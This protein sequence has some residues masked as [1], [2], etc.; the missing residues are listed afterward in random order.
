MKLVMHRHSCLIKIIS[1]VLLIFAVIFIINSCSKDVVTPP[2][3]FAG[4]LAPVSPPIELNVLTSVVGNGKI[5][6]SQ[7]NIKSGRSV[8]ITATP[9]VHYRLKEWKGDCGTF[10]N[11]SLSIS[12]KVTD[13]CFIVA[14]F[15]MIPYIVTA[16]TYEGGSVSESKVLRKYNQ[17]VSIAAKPQE[18]YVFGSWKIM[19]ESGCPTLKDASNPI[20]E[21]DVIGNCSLVAIFLKSPR[22]ITT[23]FIT[24][25]GEVIQTQEVEHGDQVDIT[26]K[27]EKHYK[28]KQWSGDCGNFSSDELNISFTAVRDCNIRIIFEKIPYTFSVTINEGGSVIKTREDVELETSDPVVNSGE[29]VTIKANP[30]RGFKFV[31]WNPSEELDCPQL[32]SLLDP[33]QTLTVE[34]NCS[35]EAVFEEL[36][37][38]IVADAETGGSV[39]PRGE[40]KVNHGETVSIQ[41]KPDPD[42]FFVEWDVKGTGCSP[43]PYDTNAQ[44]LAKG[45]CQLKAVFADIVD[46]ISSVEDN[47]DGNPT[48]PDDENGNPTD[49][50]DENG[51]PTDPDDE[52]GNPTD[53]DDE[54]GN[55]TDPDDENGNPTDPDDENGNPTDP[56]DENGNPTDPDDENGNPTDPDDENGNPTDPDDENGNPT[57]PDDENGN[58]TDPDDENGNPTDPD[59]EN[60]NPT[61]PDDENGNPTDP[62]D[63]NGN[64]TDP[65][66]ENGNPTDPD[67]E[68]GN[69]TDPDDE[70]GNPTDPDDENG[71]P[72]DPDDE[73]GDPTDPDND[74]G[75]PSNPDNDNGDPSNPDND[76][77]D[78]SNPDNDNGDP[79]NPDNDNGDPSNPDNDNGD[80]NDP[81]NDNGD[82]NDPDND[83]GDPNNPDN[84]NSDPNDP[85]N[86]NGDPN[87]PDNDNGDP[88][89]PGNDN[90]DPNNNPPSEST[91]ITYSITTSAGTGGNITGNKT[92]N[93]GDSV[94]ITAT[95]S[96]GYQVQSWGGTCGTYN[97]NTNPVS[98]TPTQSCTISVAFEKVSYTITTTAGTG[99][100]ISENQ[101]VQHGESVSITATPSTGFQVQ[102]W[103]GTCG[104]YDKTTNPVSITATKDCSISVSFEK[105]SYTITTN[106]GTGGSVTG[107]QSVK[108]GESVSITATPSIGYQVQSWG[109]TCGT[110]NKNT[111]PVSI[112]ATKD[113][114]ISVSF[115]PD[116]NSPPIDNSGDVSYTITTSAGTGGSIT[117]NQTVEQGESVSIT[118]TPSTGYQVQSWGGTC[119]T[120]NKNTNPVSFTPTQ[121]CTI[122]VAFEKV[123]YTIT[124]NA[125]TGGTI[126]GNQ[127]VQHGESVSITATPSTGYQVQSWGGTCGT[128]AKST[129]PVSITATKD[130][131]VSVAFEK[132]SYTITTNAGTGGSITG[133]QSVKHG[134]SV[135]ITATSSTGYQVQSWGGTCGTYNKN[136]NPVSIT[137]TKDCSISVAFEKVSYTITT[138]A[139]TGG[140][141]TGN[142]SVQ[143]GESVSITATSSIGYQV[144]SWSGTCGTYTKN[145][146]PVSITA[147]K[148]CSISV[149]FEKVSY[150]ITTNAGT[151][152]T[153]TGNQSVQHG[154]SVSIT[155]TP[156]T[157]YQ[158]ASWSGTCGTYAK[159]T[160]PISITATKDCSISVSFETDNNSPPI[161][162]SGDVSYTITTSAGTGGSITENQTVEQGESVSIT[163]T[164]ST[165]YQV[166]SWGGTCGTYN[167]NTNPVSFT[168][169]QSCTISVA[170]EKVSYTITTNAG[171]GGTI[172]GNQS[173][174]HGESVSITATP[175]TGYQISGWTGTCGTFSQ[176]TN[177]ATFTATKDCSI[178]VTFEK[179]SYSITTNAGTGGTITGNQSVQHG[180]SV[181]ITATPSTGYQIASWSGTC[182]TY[183]KTTNPVSITATKDC[184]ISVS[185]ETD[186]NSPPVDNSGDVSYAI[187]T[188]AGT[189]GSITEN[190]TVE[191]GESV[192]ITATPSTG[193]QVQSWGGTCGTYNK[194]TNPVSFTPTQSCTISV[195]FEKVSYTITTNAGTGGSITGNQSTEHGTTVRITATANT[196]YQISGWTGTCGT[197]TKSTNP[198]TFTATKDCSISVTFEKVSYS[199]T[200]TAGTGGSIT[201]NQTAEHGTTVRITATANTGYQ[202][203]GWTGTCG[204]FSQS[205]NPATF[206]ATK[207]CSISVTFEKVS[208][209]ITTTAGTGGTIT[210]NQSAEHGTT[211][212][213]TATPNTGYQISG[214]SGTCGTFSQSTNPATF[215]ATK[216]CTINVAFEKVSY[217][218]ST[219]AGTGGTITGNQ[220]V[221]H[222]ESV[223]ITATPSTGYQIASWSG[224]CG[225]FDKSI[226]PAIFTAT[227]DCSISVAFEKLSYTITTNA[228]TGGTITGNQSAKYQESVSITATPSTGY[229][230]A[231]WSGT[232]GTYAKTTNPVSITATKDCSINVAFEKVSYTITT[233]A[234]TGGDIT[235]NQ[236][237]KY[238]E[239]VSITATPSTGYQIAS[240]SGTCGTYAKTTNPVSITAT[241][242]CSINVA[243]EK[244]SYTI[245]TNAGTGGDITG[246]QSVKHGESVSITATP[247]TGYQIASWSGT[248]GTYAK[249]TNPIS[250]TATKDCSIS[251]SF[252]AD[253]NSPP[254]DNS[255]DVSYTVTTSA[256][257]GGSIT[258][259]QTVEQGESVSITATPSTGYQVQSW[260]GTCGSY[261]KNTNPVSFTPTQ[262]CTISVAFEKVSYTIS[263]NAGTGGTITGNQSVKHGESV[264]I[265]ATPSTGYQVQSWGGTCGSYNKN[266]NPVSFTPTQSCTISVAF[267]KVSYTISTNAGTGGTITGN[268]SVKHGE[269]VSITATPST[270]YQV[271]SW[272]GTCGTY[273][274]TANPVSITA[275]KDCSISVAFEKVSYS[276][277]TNAGTGGTITGNQSVKHGESVS[278]TA[279]PS[280]GYQVQSWGG[281][282][283]TYAKT[284]N[285][286]S[287]TATKDC[288][289]S[290]AF[291]KVS[292]SITTNAGTGGTIT[293]SQSVE[294]GES[295]SITATPT[296]GYQISGWTGTCG[297]FSQ[298]TNPATFTATKDCTINVAFEKVS[299]MITTTAGTGGTITDNQS[300]EHGESVSITVT[301]SIGYQIASWSGTCGTFSQSTN[302]AT[303]TATKD[304]SISVTFQKVSYSITTNAGTG[305]TIT[306]NQSVEHGGSVSI[307]ATPS[308]GYQIASW[309]GTCGTYAKTTNPVSITATKDCSIS[310]AFEKVSYTITT[311]AGTGGT[312]TGNQSAEHGESVSITATPSTGYQIASWGGTCGTFTESTNPAT[313]TATKD[314]SIS[315]TFE[316]V[317]YSITTTA[318]TG[319][320]ITDNQSAEHGESVSIT[321]TP[322]TGYQIASWGGTCGTFT[323]ST[324]PAT[325]TASKSCS[326]SVTFEKVSYTITTTAGT[327]GSITQNQSVKHGE[328]VSIT[329]TPSTG[330][331]IASWSGTCGTYTKSTNPVSITATKDCSISV[332]FQKVSYS[333]TTTAGTGGS[334]TGNQSVEHGESVSIT[335]TPSVGYQI[336]SWSGTCG[337][338]S[339][340]TNPATFTASKS[341]AISVAFEKKSYTITTSASTGG[342]ITENL[343]VKHGESVSITATP[344]TGYIITGWTGNCGTFDIFTNPATFTVTK[345]CS[346]SVTFESCEYPLYD[347]NGIIKARPCARS[348]IG[349]KVLIDPKDQTSQ[350][351][352]IIDRSILNGFLNHERDLRYVCTTFITDLT[353]VFS[354]APK[355]NQ[356]IGSW[357]VSNV[358]SMEGLF[359]DASLFNQDISSWEVD[360]VTNMSSMFS[361]ASAF[362]QPLN[363]WNVSN[364]TDMSLMFSNASAFD[365]PLDKWNVSNVT[366]MLGMFRSASSFNQD[367]G[368]W[369]VSNVTEM[370][371]L[372]WRTSSFNQD[373]G[374]WDV[375]SVTNMKSMFSSASSFNQD[376]GGWTVSSVTNMGSMF[377][378]APQIQSRYR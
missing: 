121:S 283:G 62:D 316:K 87:D 186:N 76:N 70:N 337:S 105:V 278:I 212:R 97:K 161:D 250:I 53:P 265:T 42:F 171:T 116:N 238:Q 88:N 247:S 125:G 319:G 91:T 2:N 30:E 245:T 181:S 293:G 166:Q 282:C 318:G 376:I 355:F 188:S 68:N 33:I 261:N 71:N 308:T 25:S 331:Q 15:E 299:Y 219:N 240:W 271:Q 264:S 366:N 254:V 370:Q 66:D 357:D 201:Q 360:N 273:A 167:K 4:P 268:Q 269:S 73:N 353:R 173:V 128:Y 180:E 311:N 340:S 333:I 256:G 60:G 248:C 65:D 334:I 150:T 13:H 114:S 98:I 3:V 72:T 41:A 345:D 178:S 154:E 324:N 280:T 27:P 169:T 140:S 153:I 104:T 377:F 155:A 48:D 213:I 279:T 303:F 14:V 133:N 244:V 115:E 229:Q 285:P 157:G 136:T 361:N 281:T 139:G 274:K 102:S 144:Q 77:G 215:T 74:N 367:I 175:T 275:T 152:G 216:D 330:Y 100:S 80:P 151:G 371:E 378:R 103:G 75:D 189:G 270:G 99:G 159:T 52:N 58:P 206:T 350:G 272:G 130:C 373:I 47:D 17:K 262:S 313:F 276:I 315:V 117:E 162:N 81:D 227:K 111:N 113:C 170:F 137:A 26:A 322:S 296:T 132:V 226:N 352:Y 231:S 317:S 21:F 230:I 198:A 242:D 109:G 246:N 191:Q 223:S 179:V 336:A 209:S 335:A 51:N 101:S 210:G 204:T 312:I 203:S 224:T 375:S 143:H 149:A 205:T 18:G 346:I 354:I 82:P 110:Y 309:S 138:N 95:P 35:I 19:E 193:Y 341:C 259:N 24:D 122:S 295:V 329:A 1:R 184:S 222:G 28:L 304:C 127:S 131:S 89:D 368:G 67:D 292:Y 339:Q 55:P 148:D 300:A 22:T 342:T 310:V 287:I 253:N 187:T 343:T 349:Q 362:D 359:L 12:L 363:K 124:T 306:G 93:K 112:T 172:T 237:A 190:Q 290:V 249:T 177:P 34:G 146:N 36:A 284:A 126:T 9:D 217:T 372:F 32:H 165:G 297:T 321:A 40:F 298:S 258:E 239:S 23:T 106:A 214:W 59:D 49:P 107:N 31:R 221:Q 119:G 199:I 358:T 141:I 197:F 158:I 347:D 233:N 202:I 142:Q 94:S 194:N 301:P 263:T 182:G 374:N 8:S 260:G 164:P 174:Q 289:I 338:F 208:Y 54:N 29:K 356:D 328:S 108:H 46:Y 365:Q 50:D 323:E 147:T 38:T 344:S 185:F 243:F 348:L 160:N 307:T 364:V 57:D 241:K 196:G 232:C 84:D 129:N 44:F 266:T 200:T 305:G 236:S 90:D 135:S 16:E 168:P 79:S 369:D 96:I 277:S 156:S 325:F 195:A 332:T 218:I 225:S 63:E 92:V 207:D 145:T 286:V 326:I 37:Y 78:P 291:E 255:G 302:P 351:Y 234:G 43:R 56:D 220:S 183:A 288:S 252:E 6:D 235:G 45:N 7:E 314:C 118:A 11:N 192:S 294:H 5:T 163:A 83:N 228:G 61:D 69:P 120:Y 320:T 64:P 123:S 176:S 10:D 251:V 327:G 85:D 134:E 257:T 20:A 39:S 211:V 86:D 267:E